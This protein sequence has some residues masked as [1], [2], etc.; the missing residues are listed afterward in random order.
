MGSIVFILLAALIDEVF[1]V[2]GAIPNNLALLAG[3]SGISAFFTGIIGIIK[4]KDRSVIV[5]IATIIGFF[6]ILIFFVF[7]LEY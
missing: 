3:I 1:G 4:S 7:G 5:F 6:I 2:I